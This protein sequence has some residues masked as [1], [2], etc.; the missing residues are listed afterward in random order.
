MHF[1]QSQWMQEIECLVFL[2]EC[3]RVFDSSNLS[4]VLWGFLSESRLPRGSTP[5]VNTARPRSLLLTP[6]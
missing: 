2:A 5:R 1:G 6:R 3:V 4:V